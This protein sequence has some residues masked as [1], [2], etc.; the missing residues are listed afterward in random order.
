MKNLAPIL[1]APSS[2]DPPSAEPGGAGVSV[3]TPYLKG[4]P[5]SVCAPPERS[6]AARN[7][8]ALL[9]AAAE[10][11]AESGPATLTMEG[12]ARRAGVG[13]GTVFRRFGSRAGLMLALLDHSEHQLQAAFIAGPPPLGPRADPART[14]DESVPVTL[15]M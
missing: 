8:R 11:I 14:G 3:A 6:D 4:P 1:L 13:K 12:V 10:L 5:V 7:R 15:Q 9:D 2:S